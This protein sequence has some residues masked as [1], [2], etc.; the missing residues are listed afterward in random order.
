MYRNSRDLLDFRLS[1]G[2]YAEGRASEFRSSDF[3]VSQ[4]KSHSRR[5]LDP[6]VVPA[7]MREAPAFGHELNKADSKD[8]AEV[9]HPWPM[10]VE[11]G[12]TRRGLRD[13][14]GGKRSRRL[15]L[16]RLERLVTPTTTEFRGMLGWLAEGLTDAIHRRAG[17]SG[18]RRRGERSGQHVL[19]RRGYRLVP[20][21]GHPT[22]PRWTSSGISRSAG[23]CAGRDG[24]EGAV[25]AW[26]LG[27]SPGTSI[28]RSAFRLTCSRFA[29]RIPQLGWD[30]RG[31][32]SG[33]KCGLTDGSAGF[34][35]DLIACAHV[36][37]RAGGWGGGGLATFRETRF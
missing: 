1:S 4:P 9:R 12:S 16:A 31:R 30:R 25:S 3:D 6:A 29:T 17:F 28:V 33:A 5:S 19:L 27:F 15:Q 34:H 24:S 13:A 36:P 11:R 35:T 26:C 20:N 2:V 21:A 7:A 18:R 23:K 37:R 14:D 32:R 10:A 22:D 8:A